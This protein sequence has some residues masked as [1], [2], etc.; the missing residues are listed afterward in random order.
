MIKHIKPGDI[1]IRGG[2]VKNDTAI[3]DIQDFMSCSAQAGEITVPTNSN[4][5]STATTYRAAAKRL[6]YNL[7]FVTRSGKVYVRKP[8]SR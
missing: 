4:A 2:G 8:V 1:P 5:K 6:G 7:E 3:A